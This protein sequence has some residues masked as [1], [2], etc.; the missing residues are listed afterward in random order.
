M[1]LRAALVVVAALFSLAASDEPAVPLR[2][3]TYKFEFRYAEFPN[4]R[5]VAELVTIQGRKVK[6]IL[7]RPQVQA[8]P[9]GNGGR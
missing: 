2:S 1:S 9:E 7:D 5:G 3:G 8:V 4:L 6:A